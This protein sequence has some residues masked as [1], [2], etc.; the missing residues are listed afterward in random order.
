MLSLIPS[1][2]P[3]PSFCCCFLLRPVRFVT[4]LDDT[5]SFFDLFLDDPT[6]PAPAAA[7]AVAAP[8]PSFFVLWIGGVCAP[9]A[10]PPLPP[11]PPDV[12]TLSGSEGVGTDG[13]RAGS[14]EVEEVVVEVAAGCGTSF[15]IIVVVV[16]V[17]PVGLDGDGAATLAAQEFGFASAGGCTCCCC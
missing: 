10:L 9:L 14:A 2:S 7:V 3:F 17:V 8:V 15:P 11:P 6:V 12:A 16:S 5:P 13:V 4:P 1:L